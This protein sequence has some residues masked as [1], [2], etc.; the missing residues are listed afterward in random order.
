MFSVKVVG[1]QPLQGAVK[2]SGSKNS[3]IKLIYAS[4]FCS[5]NVILD[6]VPN[7]GEIH[8]E[9]EIIASLGATFSWISE[10]KILIN[11]SNIN[12]FEIPFTTGSKSRLSFLAAGPL[13]FKFGKAHIPKPL[14]TNV[15]PSPY[16]RFIDTW[17]SLGFEIQEDD[18]Y[19]KVIYK[20]S[21]EKNINLKNVSHT[22]TDNAILSSI[23]LDDVT[24][25]NVSLTP[26]T[27]DLISFCNQIGAEISRQENRI[28]AVSGSKFFSGGAFKVQNDKN[29]AVLF[30]TAAILTNGNISIFGAE[31]SH[32]TPFLNYL[33]SVNIRYDFGKDEFRIWQQ[34]PIL[35]SVQLNSSPFPGFIT[36]WIPYATLIALASSGTSLINDPFYL[37]RKDFIR[38]LNLMGADIEMLK[39]SEAGFTINDKEN[40]TLIDNEPFIVAKVSGPKKLKPAKISLNDPRFNYALFLAT[41]MCDGVSEIKNGTDLERSFERIFDK[42]VDLGAKFEQ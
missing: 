11:A 20:N 34:E 31:S 32:L 18:K 12:S 26:E 29:E 8:D 38:Y 36:D 39:P 6:N 28:L 27:E 13:L 23:F 24:I 15:A 3:A 14:N 30:A 19:V 40:Y 37:S 2:I 7:I 22:G 4:L 9:L 10:N 1:S 16:K 17:I 42:F 25:N 33:N 35:N 41:L 5:E 21:N